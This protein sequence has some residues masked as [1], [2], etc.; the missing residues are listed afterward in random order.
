[1]RP[2]LC[3]AAILLLALLL[4]VPASR[5][6]STPGAVPDGAALSAAP[7][8]AWPVDGPR[9]V[10]ER[11]RAPAHAYGPGHRGIDIAAPVGVAVRAPAD[12]VIAFRGVVVDRAVLTITHAGG[13]VSSFEPVRSDLAAGSTVARG[14]VVG[15]VDVGGHTAA[16]ALHLGV[17]LDGAYLDPLLMFGPVP[18]AVL[19][20]CCASG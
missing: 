6:A 3:L 14:D 15:V 1:M 10:T 8:W 19:L 2:R 17:R 5:A 16:G 9:R 13:F 20:P 12:G 18:R 11:F 7:E 4:L